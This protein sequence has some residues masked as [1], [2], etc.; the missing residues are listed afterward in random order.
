MTTV[1]VEVFFGIDINYS[2]GKYNHVLRLSFYILPC[3][4]LKYGCKL[5]DDPI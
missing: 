2:G 1:H 3:P 5:V 4:T